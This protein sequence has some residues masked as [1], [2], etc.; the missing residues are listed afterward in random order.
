MPSSRHFEDVVDL[1]N[2]HETFTAEPDS[3]SQRSKR[4]TLHR[5]KLSKSKLNANQQSA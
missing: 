1:E 2:P 3:T 4:A 5:R